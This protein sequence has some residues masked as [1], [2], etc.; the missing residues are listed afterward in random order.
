M[1]DEL[2]QVARNHSW[3]LG[4]GEPLRNDLNK[5]SAW[6]GDVKWTS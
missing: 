6:E 3:S 1:K 2:E 4:G 5:V